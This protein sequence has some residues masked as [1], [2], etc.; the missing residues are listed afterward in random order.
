MNFDQR[1]K[2]LNTE[3]GLIINSPALAQQAATRFNAMTQPESAYIVSLRDIGPRPGHNV[4]WDTVEGGK[5]QEYYQ[6]PAQSTWRK[7]KTR[8]LALLP[9]RGEL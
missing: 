6:E 5:P 7:F 8:L 2:H 1:S 4:V 9:F 3:I